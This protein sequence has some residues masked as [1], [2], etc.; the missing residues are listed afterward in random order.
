[1]ADD[2]EFYEPED[3]PRPREDVGIRTLSARPYADGRRVR[4]DVKLTPFVERPNLEF[5]VFNAAGDPVGAMSVIE[6]MD[7]EFELTLH[8]RGPTPAGLHTLRLT[9][10]YPDGPPPVSAE[11]TF[12]VQPPNAPAGDKL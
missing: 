1:M 9:L 12:E 10:A 6:S 5:E 7:H 4:L 3:A 2:I 8:L 11:T